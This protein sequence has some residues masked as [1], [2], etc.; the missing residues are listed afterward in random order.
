MSRKVLYKLHRCSG[1][2]D[3]GSAWKFTD[4]APSGRLQVSNL[5]VVLLRDGVRAFQVGSEV[6]VDDGVRREIGSVDPIIQLSCR[7]ATVF[8]PQP[9]MDP[10]PE[11]WQLVPLEDLPLAERSLERDGSGDVTGFVRP[12]VLQGAPRSDLP[13][14]CRIQDNDVVV[15]S[16]DLKALLERLEPSLQFEPVPFEAEVDES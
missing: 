4:D 2:E 8:G 7:R 16:A 10:R 14:V 3:D 11:M 9:T 6:L 12:F 1:A 15:V 5:R 13:R